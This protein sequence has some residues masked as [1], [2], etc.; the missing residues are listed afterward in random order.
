MD[1]N[2]KDLHDV[3]NLLIAKVSWFTEAARDNA[4]RVVEAARPAAKPAAKKTAKPPAENG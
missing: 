2:A 1:E 3:I 4:H